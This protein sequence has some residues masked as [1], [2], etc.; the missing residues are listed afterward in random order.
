MKPLNDNC[1]EVF[2]ERAQAD[3]NKEVISLTCPN[4]D[5]LIAMLKESV[6]RLESGDYR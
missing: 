1:I 2:G 6:R 4:K 3:S 5:M